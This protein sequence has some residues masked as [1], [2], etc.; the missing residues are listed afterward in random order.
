VSAP[1]GE[2]GAVDNSGLPPAQDVV[3]G[4]LAAARAGS[5]HCVVVVEETH[6]VEVRFANNTTTTNGSR[7]DRR[8]TVISTRQVDGGTAAGVARRGGD[9]DVVELVRAAEGDAAGSP[10]A[11]DA[12]PFLSP[13]AAGMP[14]GPS[15]R[16][17]EPPAVTGLA[18]LSGVLEGLSG[19]FARARRAH[20]VLAGFAEHR[21]TTEYL[22]TS[23]GVRLAHGQPQG[24]LHLVARSADGIGSTWAGVG[25]TDF[26]DVSVEGLEE[27]LEERLAWTGRRL[28]RPAGRYEV[29]LPPEA[30]SDLMVGLAQELS[31][32]NA[33]DGRNVF[34][35]AGGGTRLGE[36]LTPLPFDLR[37]DPGEPGLEC[38]PFLAVT[39][40]SA[41]TSV[42]DNGL[43]LART[44]W[45]E[46]G[47]LRC[48][49]YHRAGAG[50]AGVEPAGFIGNLSL[51]VEGAGDSLDEMVARTERG[52]LLTCL[53][54][55]R[56]V[57]PITMLLTGLTRDGVYV[58]EDGQVVGAANNFRFN[59]SPVDLLSRVTEVGASVRALGREFGEYFNRTRMPPVRVPDFNMSSV[60]QAS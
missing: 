55:I 46:G 45:I 24:A 27:R 41:D 34:S 60:S 47:R 29:L 35:R 57:D 52:L 44:D 51:E 2:S 6:E 10:A 4:A 31:G 49:R 5:D 23:T 18:V 33:E 56:E 12:S 59:E 11:D 22:G 38:T 3:E 1:A 14:S 17:S 40:S 53:W 13:G 16:F 8:V 15:R 26:T 9:V 43:P 36:T 30:V 54:Y 19:A 42:F 37:S 21:E 7:R 50:R 25:T 20:H 32:R 58:V 28:E 39:S 48:L